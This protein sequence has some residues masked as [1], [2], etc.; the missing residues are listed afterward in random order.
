MTACNW[1]LQ[2]ERRLVRPRVIVALGGTAVLAV[3][4]KPMPILK[5]RGR[6]FQL[7]D[8]AQGFVT[9]HPSFLLRIPEA[10]DKQAA[11][12]AFVDDLKAAHALLR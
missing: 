7:P 10:A 6:A 3:F 12:E 9:V 4:G 8:Q 11:Y 5:N 1:W 2:N